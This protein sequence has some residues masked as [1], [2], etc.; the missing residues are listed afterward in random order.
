M[1]SH[2]LKDT[3]KRRDS[4]LPLYGRLEGTICIVATYSTTKEY[5]RELCRSEREALNQ[6]GRP[7]YLFSLP[8]EFSSPTENDTFRVLRLSTTVP[9]GALAG[10]THK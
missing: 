9:A 7:E 5:Y 8:F 2:H 1:L 10:S 6:I 3:S 4:H